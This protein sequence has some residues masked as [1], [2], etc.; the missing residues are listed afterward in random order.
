[1]DF[2]I[3]DQVIYFNRRQGI[4]SRLKKMKG[5]VVKVNSAM[6]GL[7]FEDGTTTRVSPDNL[8]K[9]AK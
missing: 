2:K 3:G 9:I 7:K 5:V 4:H 8:Q 1:M 6:I